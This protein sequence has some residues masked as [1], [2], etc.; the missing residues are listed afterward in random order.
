MARNF[1]TIFARAW[2]ASP[3]P[4]VVSANHTGWLTVKHDFAALV[5]VPV[6]KTCLF[7]MMGLRLFDGGIVELTYGG[8]TIFA[9]FERARSP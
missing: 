9:K 2:R 8:K 5:S 3:T 6:E 7:G 1:V 4:S